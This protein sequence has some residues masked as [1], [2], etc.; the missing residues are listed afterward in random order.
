MPTKLRPLRHDDLFG[1]E[2][3]RAEEDRPDAPRTPSTRMQPN[4][5]HTKFI[6]P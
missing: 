2:A 1:P 4:F 6:K 5:G 3:G